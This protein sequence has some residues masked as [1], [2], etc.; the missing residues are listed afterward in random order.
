[1]A[2]RTTDYELLPASAP[3]RGGRHGGRRE[4]PV[5]VERLEHAP[6]HRGVERAG[7][8]TVTI[9]DGDH[10]GVG[11]AVLPAVTDEPGGLTSV[12]LLVGG[13][14]LAEDRDATS[15]DAAESKPAPDIVEAALNAAG[16]KAANAVFVGDT[17]WDIKAANEA[18]MPC[19]CV[20]TGGIDERELREAGA[21]EIY[22][23]V[24]ELAERL[25]Q[26]AIARLLDT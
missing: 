21:I 11:A 3:L 19:I 4:V 22:Q 8:L 16:L 23:N 18:G 13:A 26:S 10:H 15:G 20:L 12:G 24:A 5:A 9:L 17:V 1:M 14:G 7:E 2:L 25:D 6:G